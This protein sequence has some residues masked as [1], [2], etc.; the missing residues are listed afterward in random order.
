MIHPEKIEKIPDVNLLFIRRIGNY[1]TS[2]QSA[3]DA[4]LAFVKKSRLETKVRYFSISH[5]DPYITSEDK[6]RFDACIQ[7][8]QGIQEEGEIARQTLKGGKYAIFT[9]PGSHNTLTE[10]FDRIFLKWLPETKENNNE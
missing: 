2:S 5:D 6:L 4:M 8:P 7:V 9:H 10:T 3:W 1:T